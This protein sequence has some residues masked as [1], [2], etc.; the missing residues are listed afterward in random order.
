MKRAN[1]LFRRKID[2][3]CH[4]ESRDGSSHTP[5]DEYIVAMYPQSSRKLHEAPA[6][7]TRWI[8]IRWQWFLDTAG[9]YVTHT[10]ALI[11]AINIARYPPRESLKSRELATRSML[12]F[13]MG[14]SVSQTFWMRSVNMR[15]RE[16]FVPTRIALL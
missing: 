11:N 8:H 6:H 7:H 12:L 9:I 5:A 4:R 1:G 14:P 3:I 16:S 10:A 13:R 2:P 15:C